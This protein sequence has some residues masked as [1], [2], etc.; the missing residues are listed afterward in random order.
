MIRIP[1]RFFVNGRLPVEHFEPDELLYFRFSSI[2]FTDE[3]RLPVAAIKFPDFSVNRG[4][5][6]QPTDVLIPHWEGWGI[7]E[8]EVQAIPLT[9]NSGDGR[10]FEFKVKHDPIDDKHPYYTQPN[11]Q[12]ENYAHSEVRVFENGEHL[13]RKLTDSVKKQFR[14]KMSDKTKIVVILEPSPAD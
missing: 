6:S 2:H 10:E 9:L 4:K 8:F 3:S 7:A 13:K 14:M 5:F 1:D 11:Q 12:F